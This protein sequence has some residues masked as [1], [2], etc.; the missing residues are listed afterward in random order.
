MWVKRGRLG[1]TQ[2]LHHNVTSDANNYGLIHFDTNN[3]IEMMMT[4]SG[5]HTIK[6]VTNRV[7]RD[8]SAWYHFVF[9]TDVNNS[10]AQNRMRI[11][12][13]GVEETSFST[14]DSPSGA[15]N[16][17]Y[18]ASASNDHVIGANSAGTGN[19]DGSMSHVYNIV[20]TVYTPSAFGST[21]STTGQWKINTS[22]SVT[23]GS[24][25]YLILKD[26]N[27]ITDQSIN[28]NDFTLG[29]GNLTK[30]EDCPDNIFNCWD[31]NYV[32][33][34]DTDVST[35]YI[36][37]G[38]T[39]FNAG[40]SAKKGWKVGTMSVTS[41]KYYWEAK[42][43]DNGRMYM[44]IAYPQELANTSNAFYDNTTFTAITIDNGGSVQGINGQSYSSGVSFPNGSYVG[45]ALDMD[46]KALYIR[47][48]NDA[49]INSGN[50]TSGSSRTGSVIEQLSGSRDNY[51]GLDVVSPLV[52]DPSTSGTHN[53]E[54]NF[55]NGSF[56]I[57]QL[58][59]TTYQA[60]GL[61]IF[62]YQ[63]PTGYT[64]LCTKG[65]NL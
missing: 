27:T 47:K 11:Y 14:N 60:T 61:G 50:P 25:G 2:Y 42:V 37:N 10:T 3:Q 21:D 30:T 12:V 38:N 51:L 9:V 39:T 23:F 57:T 18:E 19:F 15:S 8:T 54:F 20:D 6:R 63:P 52:G 65:V 32:T 41:G 33:K 24:Q 5:S 7:F 35:M 56:G 16:R 43:V 17:F 1:T 34:Y 36:R 48:N 55:G 46:N 58:T 45:F 59:G 44:G 4:T 26:S 28:S 22:P 62:K 49:W 53:S 40:S 64:A 13:N 29:A 31:V